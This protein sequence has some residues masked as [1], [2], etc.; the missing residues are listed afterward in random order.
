MYSVYS[1]SLIHRQASPRPPDPRAFAGALHRRKEVR[2]N[3]ERDLILAGTE[4]NTSSSTEGAD[5]AVVGACSGLDSARMSRG[6]AC[7]DLADAEDQELMDGEEGDVDDEMAMQA[8]AHIR[9]GAPFGAATFVPGV[10]G[11]G[12]DIGE[13]MLG[14]PRSAGTLGLSGLSVAGQVDRGHEGDDLGLDTDY[15]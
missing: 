5:G 8:G 11:V 14:E 6:A 9:D 3:S 4:G 1:L 15:L 10:A 7:F 12:E 13:D 2:W